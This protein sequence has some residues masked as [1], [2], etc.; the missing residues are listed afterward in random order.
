MSNDHGQAQVVHLLHLAA[1]GV[2]FLVHP[3][4]FTIHAPHLR[5]RTIKI[6]HKTGLWDQVWGDLACAVSSYAVT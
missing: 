4:A 2:Q 6:T 5:A 1:S 3:R